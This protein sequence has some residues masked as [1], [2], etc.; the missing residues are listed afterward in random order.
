[1][2]ASLIPESFLIDT[3]RESICE[4]ERHQT[5]AT[6]TLIDRGLK[7]GSI[8]GI[9]ARPGKLAKDSINELRGP[10]GAEFWN[11]FDPKDT[12]LLAETLTEEVHQRPT[13]RR[14]NKDGKVNPPVNIC[15]FN[16]RSRPTNFIIVIAGQITSPQAN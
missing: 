5:D 7:Q 6:K 8:A 13:W 11:S 14:V 10:R 2:D 9:D 12:R 3:N 1:M 15:S 4:P 16:G